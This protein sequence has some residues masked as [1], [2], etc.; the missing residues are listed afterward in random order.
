MSRYE[1]YLRKVIKMKK[2]LKRNYKTILL[3][4][5]VII[6]TIVCFNSA[7][8]FATAQRHCN[9][10]GG[11]IFILLIPYLVWIY[12]QNYKDTVRARKKGAKK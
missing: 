11:E 2:F 8:N 10:L 7:H 6:A 4:V 1:T 9:A 12:Y 3:A 5:A